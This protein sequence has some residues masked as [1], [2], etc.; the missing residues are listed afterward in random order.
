VTVG[1]TNLL[2]RL[3]D[4]VRGH[5]ENIDGP[6]IGTA[7]CV[8]SCSDDEIMHPVPIQVSDGSAGGAKVGIGIKR[9]WQATVSVTNLLSGS[10]HGAR[11]QEEYVNRPGIRSTGIISKCSDNQVRNPV[12]VQVPNCR[13]G[14]TEIVP[15]V[16]REGQVPVQVTDFLPRFHETVSGQRHDVKCSGSGVAVVVQKC[17]HGEVHYAIPI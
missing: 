1:S 11:C 8:S 16:E 15:P 3:H 7:V 5:K 14:D 13:A 17:A 10:D 12:P 4:A 2:P 9:R 6:S